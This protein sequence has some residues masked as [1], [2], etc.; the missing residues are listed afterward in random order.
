MPK[1]TNIYR[2]DFDREATH[3]TRR[4]LRRARAD[5]A[6]RFSATLSVHGDFSAFE[7]VDR[8]GGYVFHAYHNDYS[9]GSRGCSILIRKGGRVVAT[10]ACCLYEGKPNM[11]EVIEQRG[12]YQDGTN[13][14]LGFDLETTRTWFEAMSGYAAFSGGIWVHPDTR[15]TDFSHTLVPLLP[16]LGR[17][18]ATECWGADH[19]FALI[20]EAVMNKGVGSR[21]ALS[22]TAPG[23]EWRHGEKRI[24]MWFG[25]HPPI[26]IMRDAIAFI[27][28]G[29]ESLE[30]K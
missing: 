21:Y 2:T 20:P 16:V 23:I 30:L 14:H 29:M 17:A 1:T 5:L 24:P 28:T 27:A 18:I 8:L 15:G 25:Y 22:M 11:A 12:L 10:Y 7:R 19:V 9:L 4:L 26:L 3:L 6:Q 13:D